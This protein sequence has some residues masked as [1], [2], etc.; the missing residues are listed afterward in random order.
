MISK[1]ELHPSD[2]SKCGFETAYFYLCH[3]EVGRKVYPECS[4]ND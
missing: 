4:E 3:L 2:E 1:D